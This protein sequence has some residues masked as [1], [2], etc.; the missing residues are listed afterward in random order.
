M[1]TM[2]TKRRRINVRSIEERMSAKLMQIHDCNPKTAW[3][4]I[5]LKNMEN[6][7]KMIA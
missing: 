5:K 1:G 7:L 4:M 6:E 2:R 3:N